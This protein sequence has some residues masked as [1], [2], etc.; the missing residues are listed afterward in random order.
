MS[1]LARE[2]GLLVPKPCLAGLG[3][4]FVVPLWK[5]SLL[6]A[7]RLLVSVLSTLWLHSIIPR[8]PQWRPFYKSLGSSSEDRG[9]N[10]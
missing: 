8:M 3:N 2:R 7:S 1:S 4:V 10:K 6:E 5:S 9:L